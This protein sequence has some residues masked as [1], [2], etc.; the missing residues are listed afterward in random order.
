MDKSHAW[1]LPHYRQPMWWKREVVEPQ[2][3]VVC[4]DEDME[5]IL[6]SIIFVDTLKYNIIDAE[7]W[8]NES[9]IYYLVST[10]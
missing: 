8:S 9:D 4:S 3:I 1:I 5:K 10:T 7:K 2:N 6:E